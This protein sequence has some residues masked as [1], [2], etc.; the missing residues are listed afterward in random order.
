[1]RSFYPN[2]KPYKV[3]MLAVEAPHELYVE[4]CGSPDGIPVLFV[5]G[6]PGA[7]C[8]AQDRCFFDPEKYRIILFDQRGCGRSTPHA[9]LENNNSQALVDDIE[10]IREALGVNKWLLFGGSWGSTL[11]LIYAQAHPQ[12]V[13]GLILRG[14]F[15]CRQRDIHWFYQSGADHIFPDYWRDYLE[16]IPA[17]ERDDMVAAYHR[18]L[19]GDNE[20]ERMSAAKAWSVWEGRCATLHPNPQVV[21]RLG[22][23]HMALAMARVECHYFYHGA[24]LKEN[25]LLANAEKLRGIPGIIVHGRYDAVCPV[26]QAFALHR[27]WPQAR[28]EIIRDAGH[29]SSEPGTL[30]A[31]VKA[32]DE[33]ANKLGDLA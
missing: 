33:M 19:T 9:S 14:I 16:P 23:P 11:S 25:Q 2:I 13:S 28:L 7:G 20:L 29:A 31:L 8:S 21:E 22:S 4:E 15:L 3:N 12:R 30:D 26:D 17:S 10:V 1:M 27:V 18:R 5:H 6:G 24:F 32:T